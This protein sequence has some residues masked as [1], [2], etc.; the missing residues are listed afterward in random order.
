LLVVAD[1][2]WEADV[3]EELR[4]TGA[5]ILYTTRSGDLLVGTCGNLPLRVDEVTEG[6]AAMLLRRAAELDDEATL[7]DPAYEMIRRGGLA[8]MD[9]ACVGRWD[10]VRNRNDEAAWAMALAKITDAQHFMD[11]AALLPWRS[12]VLLA[13]LEQLTLADERNKELYLSLAVLPSNLSVSINDL[14][15][16]LTGKEGCSGPDLQAARRVVATLE[17]QSVLVREAGGRYRVHGSHADVA[18]QGISTCPDILDRALSRWRN[19]VSSG[20]AVFAWRVEELVTI[21]QTM[22]SLES[23]QDG[24]EI[25]GQYGAVADAVDLSDFGARQLLRRIA[26][27]QWLMQDCDAACETWAKLLSADLQVDRASQDQA[28][29]T[30]FPHV[31]VT[32]YTLGV[33]ALSS[34]RTEE[35]ERWFR[36][37]LCFE[38]KTLGAVDISLADTLHQ[39][40]SCASRGGRAEEAELLHLRALSIREESQ[41]S[42]HPDVAKTLHAV[43]LLVLK[44]GRADE[45]ESYLRRALQ[46]YSEKLGATD[47]KMSTTLY[48]LGRCLTVAGKSSEAE[49]HFQRAL[50]IQEEAQGVSSLPVADTLYALGGCMAD[51]GRTAAAEAFHRRALAIREARLGAADP[52]TARAARALAQVLLDSG[53]AKEAEVLFR[54]GL[55]YVEEVIGNK[56]PAVP[57]L[58]ESL[59]ACALAQEKPEEAIDR[60][61]A[62]L[63]IREETL[64]NDH[65][66]VAHTLYDLGRCA[67]QVERRDDAEKFYRKSL[68]VQVAN[69]GESHEEVA[70]VLYSLA[71]CVAG[72]GGRRE[73]VEELL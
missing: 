32:M 13:C 27:V 29:E 31:G 70:K 7:P 6:E 17:K 37:A 73:E 43:G 19:N 64:G 62:A 68:E 26:Q 18:W 53:N 71:M 66:S 3:L 12:A 63:A 54:R 34:G 60:F 40:A 46:I 47:T 48:D 41:G 36:K 52:A 16:L 14:T 39:I 30:E 11:G 57:D 1:D 22:T 28:I 42:E 50:S 55:V 21:W 38:E 35:A 51:A 49:E 67:S 15:V 72:Q 33:H 45:A 25:P 56:H 24:E 59:G 58:L 10:M 5:S 20:N 9:L 4:R 65:P 8:A 69:L 61:Q 2:V 44:E 23:D